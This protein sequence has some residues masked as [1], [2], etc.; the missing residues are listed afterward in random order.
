MASLSV[1]TA[2]NALVAANWTQTPIYT[3]NVDTKVPADNSPF[4]EVTFLVANETQ[5]SFGAP[6]SNVYRE[7]GGF[8]CILNVP[9]GRRLDTFLG[10]VDDLRAAL[11]GHVSGTLVLWEAAPA[12]QGERTEDGAYY[13]ISFAV[14]YRYD[15]FA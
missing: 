5:S 6:G 2:V 3:L 14:P 4:L 9:V 10:W 8:R 13:Q 7:E 1:I 12:V 11:R 15:L